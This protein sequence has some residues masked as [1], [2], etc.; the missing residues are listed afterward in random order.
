LSSTEKCRRLMTSSRTGVPA[1]TV[2]DRGP[3]SSKLI[4]PAGQ[5]GF[6]R[7]VEDPGDLGDTPELSLAAVLKE[8]DFLEPLNLVFLLSPKSGGEPKL[9]GCF[10]RRRTHKDATCSMKY[11]TGL[12]LACTYCN[13]ELPTALLLDVRCGGAEATTNRAR[14]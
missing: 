5:N 9:A 14:G 4:S 13:T 3:P 8:G 2:A 11:G 12:T 6:S 10:T 7:N 1:T